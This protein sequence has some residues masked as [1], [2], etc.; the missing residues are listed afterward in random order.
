M[1][2]MLLACG[3]DAE[4]MTMLFAD[5]VGFTGCDTQHVVGLFVL[6]MAD[7]YISISYAPRFA[8]KSQ[9]IDG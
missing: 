3:I 8:G 6:S 5:I 9:A 1:L 7:P 4:D 2:Q